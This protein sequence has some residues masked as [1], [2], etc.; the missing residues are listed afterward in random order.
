MTHQFD[1]WKERDLIDSTTMAGRLNWFLRWAGGND[2]DHLYPVQVNLDIVGFISDDDN[3]DFRHKNRSRGPRQNAALRYEG[4]MRRDKWFQRG[5]WPLLYTTEGKLANGFTRMLAIRESGRPQL[6]EI[7]GPVSPGY[8]LSVDQGDP[9]SKSDLLSL[10]TTIK[11]DMLPTKLWK[12][13]RLIRYHITGTPTQQPDY[14]WELDWLTERY[15]R[16]YEAVFALVKERK[17]HNFRRACC[18]A[19]FTYAHQAMQETG[20]GDELLTHWHDFVYRQD[21]I[22]F[23]KHPFMPMFRRVYNCTSEAQYPQ[24]MATRALLRGIGALMAG[25]KIGTLSTKVTP[26]FEDS[27]FNDCYRKQ[28]NGI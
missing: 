19:A 16:S 3:I 18:V 12:V 15:L 28:L 23:P 24:L 26:L 6:L 20:R 7:R 5:G 22:A 2:P 17:I 10:M 21:E 14:G 13:L 25:R 8:V 27:N 11:A 9:R 1:P 4:V